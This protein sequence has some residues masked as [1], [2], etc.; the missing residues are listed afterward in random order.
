MKLHQL[1]STRF[2]AAIAIVILHFGTN[3]FPFNISCVKAVFSNVNILV[4]Y[5]FVLSGFVMLIANAKN[6]DG[7]SYGQYYLNRF[8]RIY[9]LYF[10]ALLATCVFKFKGFKL[11]VF[12]IHVLCLQTYFPNLPLTLNTAAWSLSDEAFFY[13]LFPVLFNQ[14]YTKVSWRTTASL[15]IVF[16]ILSQAALALLNIYPNDAHINIPHDMISYSPI[17]HLNEFLMGNLAGMIFLKMPSRCFRNYGWALLLLAGIMVY[18]I[19]MQHMVWYSRPILIL[20]FSGFIFGLS[21]NSRGILFNILTNKWLVTGG[22]ISYGIYIFQFPVYLGV[23]WVNHFTGIFHYIS[24]FYLTFIVLIICS[25][26][27]FYKIEIPGMH[28]IKS[29]YQRRRL[30]AV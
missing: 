29:L 15:I 16:F 23:Y 4:S 1:T 17:A 8:A 21:L 13:L 3:S 18:L 30:S 22:D 26:I 7:I 10:I 27:G 2:F 9:P 12:L 5:F 19:P 24:Q 28:K 11:S 6:K 25:A 14:L 20:L